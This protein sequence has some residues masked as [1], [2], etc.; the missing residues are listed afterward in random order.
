MSVNTVKSVYSG[1]F[2]FFEWFIS[3][4]WCFYS[5]LWSTLSSTFAA[6]SLNI[7]S[8]CFVF[9]QRKVSSVTC[10]AGRQLIQVIEPFSLAYCCE[11]KQVEI[12]NTIGRVDVCTRNNFSES[13]RTHTCEM[14]CETVTVYDKNGEQERTIGGWF[15]PPFTFWFCFFFFSAVV[16]ANWIS[17]TAIVSATQ[18]PLPT[19]AIMKPPKPSLKYEIKRRLFLILW[20]LSTVLKV[21]V[22]LLFPFYVDAYRKYAR[23]IAITAITAQELNII[24]VYS[25]QPCWLSPYCNFEKTWNRD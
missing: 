19:A 15:P 23:A 20:R 17:S 14:G 9:L 4:T 25:S 6:S 5:Q 1:L 3:K 18:P 7:S 12:L 24:S 22:F 8:P 2:F 10:A 13:V 11:G 16:Q 21:D